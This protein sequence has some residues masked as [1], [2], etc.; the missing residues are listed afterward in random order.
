MCGIAGFSLKYDVDNIYPATWISSLATDMMS[1]GKDATG[2]V[3]VSREGTVKLTKQD[4]DAVDFLTARPNLGRSARTALIHTRAATQG[5]PK[6]HLN[7]HPINYK[8]IIGVHNGMIDN[9]DDLYADHTWERYGKV[10]SEAIFAAIHHLDTVTALESIQG[11][12]AIAWIDAVDPHTMWLARGDSSPLFI[13]S[14]S[15]GLF[16]AS[17]KQ[18]LQNLTDG[19]IKPRE[20]AEGTL[21]QV[22]EGEI[23]D[24]YKFKPDGGWGRRWYTTSRSGWTSYPST[25]TTKTMLSPD[26]LD[27]DMDAYGTPLR[28][29]DRIR[30]CASN[31]TGLIIG[32]EETTGKAWVDWDVSDIQCNDVVLVAEGTPRL[33][34]TPQDTDWAEIDTMSDAEWAE[35]AETLADTYSDV[36]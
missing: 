25:N 27:R 9:D 13:H 2:V 34:V 26:R 15:Q 3:T 20:V 32:I 16:F 17:T 14:F 11:S 6:N 30:R 23:V 21:I 12:M 4:T 28:V 19:E 7:N 29:G 35:V 8:S 5:S 24:E 22:R 31:A 10:D 18:A 33:G 1:R 36:N